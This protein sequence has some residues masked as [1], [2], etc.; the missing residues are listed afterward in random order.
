MDVTLRRV[1][2]SDRVTFAAWFGDPDL[3][4]WHGNPDP[5]EA[6][7]EFLR[8]LRSRYNFMIDVGGK[9]VGHVAVEG[10]WDNGTSAELGILIDP[11]SRQRGIGTTALTLVM[12]FAF[13]ETRI[14]RLWAGVASSNTASLRLCGRAGLVEEGRAR[15]AAFED[16]RWIDHIY[17]SV[18]SDEWPRLKPASVP[19][20][21]AR[22]ESASLTRMLNRTLRLGL[23]AP[24]K[25]TENRRPFKQ[26][27]F[28]MGAQR[29][30]IDKALALAAALEDEE[31][32]RKM[33]LRK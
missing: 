2:P 7:A 19:R 8:I 25:Q 29:V 20:D 17:F 5:G 16:G 26:N 14:H 33:S 30:G 31:I 12:D 13:R 6:N 32:A 3:T 18:L 11:R 1:S 10:D 27:T 15:D 28:R 23:A 22:T 4:R 9:P 24:R 21:R